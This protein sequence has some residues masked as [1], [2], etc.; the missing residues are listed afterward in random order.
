MCVSNHYSFRFFESSITFYYKV[1]NIFWII[2]L[3]ARNSVLY[4]C[5]IFPNWNFFIIFFVIITIIFWFRCRRRFLRMIW[6]SNKI[7]NSSTWSIMI[8]VFDFIRRTSCCIICIPVLIH[9]I[10]IVFC[11]W[12]YYNVHMTCP[13]TSPNTPVAWLWYKVFC[14]SNYLEISTSIIR[15]L[16]HSISISPCSK[17]PIFIE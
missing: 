3:L 11:A 12:P 6:W 15:F 1:I 5:Y 14:I 13:T 2:N 16:S 7:F 9:T 10:P 8:R 4:S 17:S